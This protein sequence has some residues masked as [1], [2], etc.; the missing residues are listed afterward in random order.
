MSSF[1]RKLS[2]VGSA[3]LVSRI[4][5]FVRDSLVAAALGTGPVAEAYMVAI[6]IANMFRR[7]FAEGA[8]SNAFV[9]LFVKKE[10]SEQ[11][12]FVR[13]V[14]SAL[15]M[16]LIVLTIIF[17]IFMPYAVMLLA[18]GFVDDTGKFQITVDFCRLAFFYL[19]FVSLSTLYGGIL[20]GYGKFALNAYSSILPNIFAIAAL[21]G[22]TLYGM[23][24]SR[25]AGAILTAANVVGGVAQLI[26]VIWGARK[27]GMT[28]MLTIPR[29]TDDVKKLLTIAMPTIFSSGVV[30]INLVV[31]SAIA[32]LQTGAVAWLY[33][34][35]RLYQLPLGIVGI[36]VGTVLLPEISLYKKQGDASKIRASLARGAEVCLILTLPCAVMLTFAPDIL[37]RGLFERGAFTPAD[38]QATALALI[39]FAPGIVA[40]VLMRVYQTAYYAAGE[41][42]T[43]MRFAIINAAA[44]VAINVALFPWLGYIACA[45]ST[46]IAAWINIWMLWNGL[47]KQDQ[48]RLG[49]ISAA[50]FTKIIV[51]NVM[52]AGFV[53]LL[54][55]F[56]DLSG[57][58]KLLSALILCALAGSLYVSALLVFFRSQIRPFLRR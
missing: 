39:A 20:N 28:A 6:R 23:G 56:V 46:T 58:G 12:G 50:T 2:G 1:L 16:A 34:A 25:E 9:P 21:G 57:F 44:N 18:P 22:V 24:A 36:A 54:R 37:V 17:Q 31:G 10:A 26:V 42:K 33:M 11:Q 30:Q 7:V 41:T 19:S 8:F 52:L 13:E 35:D 55:E 53:L 32:S 40:F 49:D 43:M 45:I 38:T 14:Q 15:L 29:Y 5:G 48:V 51:A 4:L 27:L 3:T 47:S